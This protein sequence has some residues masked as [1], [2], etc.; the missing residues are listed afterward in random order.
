LLVLCIIKDGNVYNYNELNIEEGDYMKVNRSELEQVLLQ[1]FEDI[2]SD[3]KFTEEL[4]SELAKYNI[5]AGDVQKIIN[6]FTPIGELDDT[7][8]FLITKSIHSL[9]TENR[10]NPETYFNE[11]EIQVASRHREDLDERVKLPITIENVVYLNDQEF[12]TALPIK[13]LVEW[14]NSQLIEYNPETQRNPKERMKRGKIVTLANVNKQSVKEIVEHILNKTY[15]SDTIILNLLADGRD[16]LTYDEKHARLTIESGEIDILDGFHRLNAFSQVINQLNPDE[17]LK[18]QVSIKNFTTKE[19]QAYVAQINTVNKM[20]NTYIQK[21][22][23]DR[24]SDIVA[25]ELQ[26]ESELKNRVSPTH[27]LN[28]AVGHLVSYKLLTEEIDEQFKINSKI[29]A[30][31]LANYLIVFFDYLIGSFPEEFAKDKSGATVMS[32]HYMFIGYLTLAKHMFENE[33]PARSVADVVAKI[34]LTED[35][36]F[37]QEVKDMNVPISNKKLKKFVRDYF[38][39]IPLEGSLKGV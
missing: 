15:R 38:S 12:I 13:T 7:L 6:Q 1:K 24:Y 34:D 4:K 22:R 14:D 16:K 32:K 19:A 33:V 27:L 17:D 29:E 18:I 26:K 35:N 11:R 2:K 39:K 5:L 31:N 30:L 21:L 23:A 28:H 8:L 3:S 36:P 20:P 25:K 37:I 9:T 10:F